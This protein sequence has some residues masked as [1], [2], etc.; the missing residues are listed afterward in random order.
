MSRKFSVLMCVY[1]KEKESNLKDCLDSIFD[2]TKKPNQVVVVLDGKLREGLMKILSKYKLDIF[3]IEERK[4]LIYA[5]NYG[6]EKCKYDLVARMDSDD[7]CM[8][9]R[10]ELLLKEFTK[11]KSL[12]LVGGQILE[13]DGKKIKIPDLILALYPCCTLNSSGISL[14]G[15]VTLDNLIL[16]LK[17]TTYMRIAYRGYYKNELDPFLNQMKA[18]EKLL[19]H[20]PASR[21]FLATNDGL[22]DE[23]VRF[24]NKLSQI[25]GIDVKAYDF[26]YYEH[27]FM[28]N[29][30][31]ILR[32]AP[33]NIFFQEIK[34]FIKK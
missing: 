33:H 23:A 11:D 9:N 25:N 26:A 15:C 28:G 17:D 29:K 3:E 13:F 12:V 16:S 24:I 30:S 18:N 19:N 10:F 21:F 27:G 4:G 7:I 22:R 1:D 14:S 34:E 20:F 31:K 32:E 5:L 6:L 2:Q 8:K